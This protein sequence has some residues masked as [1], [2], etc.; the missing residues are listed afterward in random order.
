M[1]NNTPLK[2]ALYIRVSTEEQALGGQSAA[3]QAEVLKQYCAAYNIELYQVYEDLGFSGKSFRDRPGLSKLIEDSRSR[4]FDIVLVWKI[5]RLSRSLKDLLLIIDILERNGI[6]FSSYTER[7]D[8]STP[9]GRMTLQLLGSIAEFE[10]NTIIENVKLGLKE[11]GRKGGK[12][13]SVLGYDNMDKKLV[14]NKQEAAAVRTIYDLYI[15]AGMSFSSIAR[16]LNKLGYRTKRN[17]IF[18]GSGISEIISNP[19]Y[20]GINRHNVG[21]DNEY[22]VQGSHEPIISLEIWN[23]A[24]NLR[25]KRKKVG[26]I[27]STGTALLSGLVICKSCG[28]PMNIF[29]TYSG[30]KAYRYYRCRKSSGHSR[31]CCGYI[32]ADKL[33]A[34]VLDFLKSVLLC[35]TVVEDIN[36]LINNRFHT[37]YQRE[38]PDVTLLNKELKT[39]IKS[40]SRY[41]KLFESFKISDNRTF[42]ERIDELESRIRILKEKKA[43]LAEELPQTEPTQAY[44]L[45]KIAFRDFLC[46]LEQLELKAILP[47]IISS[48][49]ASK[50]DT[51]IQTHFP[52]QTI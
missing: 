16:Q 38:A 12:A 35:S 29:Y 1:E 50:N 23:E 21:K 15:N 30:N 25:S 7:F 39:L 52:I 20:I 9:V 18:R 10:R 3:A 5:S 2:A 48:I 24:Q 42:I 8:T 4:R 47:Y 37:S 49:K 31:H 34:R 13:S 17:C 46:S 26:N 19:V 41:L 6:S 32:N 14:V 45:Y 43:Y 40:R 51:D 22:N 11:F 33:D 36:K 27:S 28:S 44:E